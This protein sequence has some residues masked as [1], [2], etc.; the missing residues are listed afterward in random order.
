MCVCV[1]MR[2]CMCLFHCCVTACLSVCS[3]RFVIPL[4]GGESVSVFLWFLGCLGVFAVVFVCMAVCLPVCLPLLYSFS[5]TAKRPCVC[6]SAEP[7]CRSDPPGLYAPAAS[8]LSLSVHRHLSSRRLVG[9]LSAG[10]AHSDRISTWFG[11]PYELE[12]P[13]ELD[14]CRIFF[15]ETSTTFHC[16]VSPTAEEEEESAAAEPFLFGLLLTMEGDSL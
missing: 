15:E 5:Y 10:R 14:G 6:M 7:V 1:S 16:I 11:M 2:I 4:F 12:L 9:C 8:P 3:F 13:H